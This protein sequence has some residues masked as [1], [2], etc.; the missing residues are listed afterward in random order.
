[1]SWLAGSNPALSATSFPEHIGLWRSLLSGSTSAPA[2]ATAV[3]LGDA[4]Q[5]RPA[6]S[7][8]M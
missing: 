2:Q 3:H 5:I 4:E 8:H 6:P 7:E 1:M